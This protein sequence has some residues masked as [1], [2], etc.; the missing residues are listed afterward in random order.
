MEEFK[1]FEGLYT[2]FKGILGIL[3]INTLIVPGLIKIED[4]TEIKDV[5][6]YISNTLNNN[7][8]R[9][10]TSLKNTLKLKKSSVPTPP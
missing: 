1:E 10:R 3:H 7:T 8:E 6:D 5:K 2:K 9:T 4:T